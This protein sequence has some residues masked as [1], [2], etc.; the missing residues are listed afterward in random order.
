MSKG[1]MATL[2]EGVEDLVQLEALE[3]EGCQN[4]QGYLF[5]KPVAADEVTGLLH[6]DAGYHWRLRA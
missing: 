5:S 3:S 6:K 2:A 1:G 4:I